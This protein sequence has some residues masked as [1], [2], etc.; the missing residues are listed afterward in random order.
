MRNRCVQSP[1]L[2]IRCISKTLNVLHRHQS[3]RRSKVTHAVPVW[4]SDPVPH[5]ALSITVHPSRPPSWS[6]Y[7][8]IEILIEAEREIILLLLTPPSNI[9]LTTTVHAVST[10]R[11]RAL[12]LDPGGTTTA[13][14]TGLIGNIIMGKR[15]PQRTVLAAISC[16]AG[17]LWS[18]YSCTSTG[19]SLALLLYLKTYFSVAW[20]VQNLISKPSP[21]DRHS[22]SSTRLKVKQ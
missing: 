1:V 8:R 2:Q 13:P 22:T 17:P 4:T 9:C 15:W 14:S 3:G 5:T 16:A 20:K 21:S 12:Q 7:W 11:P 18:A 10:L 19:S 6:S